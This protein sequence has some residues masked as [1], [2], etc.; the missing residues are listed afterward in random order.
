MLLLCLPG[1]CLLEQ[2]LQLLAGLA[3]TDH[4]VAAPARQQH[5]VL[6]S[7]NCGENAS[8]QLLQGLAGN[9][10]NTVAPAC[11]GELLV[12]CSATTCSCLLPGATLQ[13]GAGP[14]C[15]DLQVAA[16]AWQ[17]YAT[18]G[19][20]KLLYRVALRGL[21]APAPARF[22]GSDLQVAIPARQ[23]YVVHTLAA[24]PMR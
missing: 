20:S 18:R 17:K 8:S 5:A 15:S 22:A 21:A 3:C 13:R 6:V 14:T 1:G 4:K 7:G 24:W 16:V 11:Q 12:S 19:R 9:V 23:A 2:S 10:L